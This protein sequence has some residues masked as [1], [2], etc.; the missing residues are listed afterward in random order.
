[1]DI[2]YTLNFYISLE[3]GYVCTQDGRCLPVQEV[4]LPLWKH[5]EGGKDPK[6]FGFRF[7]ADDVWHNIQVGTY[8]S[9]QIKPHIKVVWRD[10]L[11]ISCFSNF[12][13][14]RYFMISPF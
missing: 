2:L 4:D 3:V 13:C 12:L 11:L 1:M 9:N 5:G 8:N 6:D 14:F 7:K 10:S